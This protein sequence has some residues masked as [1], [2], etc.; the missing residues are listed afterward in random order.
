MYMCIYVYLY[1]KREG[2]VCCWLV[3]L[4]RLVVDKCLSVL[5]SY[6]HQNMTMAFRCFYFDAVDYISQLVNSRA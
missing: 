6:I 2:A 5:P 3:K 1:M 4:T